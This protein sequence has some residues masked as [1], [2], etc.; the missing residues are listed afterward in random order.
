MA[1]RYP[2]KAAGQILR[3]LASLESNAE[4]K[5]LDVDRIRLVNVTAHKGGLTKRFIPRAQGRTTPKNDARAHV[6]VVGR[7]F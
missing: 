4:F 2:V 3:L 6:E 7:E 5:G 1:G